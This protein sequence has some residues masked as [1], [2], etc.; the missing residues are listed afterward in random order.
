MLN[1]TWQKV[2][3]TSLQNCSILKN[4][5]EHNKCNPVIGYKL[6]HRANMCSSSESAQ[7]EVLARGTV[8]G[9]WLRSNRGQRPAEREPRNVCVGHDSH[10]LMRSALWTLC[11]L[12][13]R[14]SSPSAVCSLTDPFDWLPASFS[15]L[16]LPDSYC[17]KS[18]R[19]SAATRVE[20]SSQQIRVLSDETGRNQ[21]A[22]TCL[23]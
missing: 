19:L 23:L 1:W 18:V 15:L 2:D 10:W 21:S 3:V 20:S 14:V 13:R 17:L 12:S 9:S 6:C 7:N 4:C 22:Q 11:S 16:I 8:K 5:T